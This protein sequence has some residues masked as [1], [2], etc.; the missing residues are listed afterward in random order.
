MRLST[1]LEA[2]SKTLSESAG[3]LTG[4][5]VLLVTFASSEL[6]F[7]LMQY[8]VINYAYGHAAWVNGLRVT[9]WKHGVLSDGDFL[10]GW[11]YVAFYLGSFVLVLPFFFGSL[12]LFSYIG[13]RLRGRRLSDPNPKR[14]WRSSGESD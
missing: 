8:L 2:Y 10:S 1:K 12:F 14:K 13:L 6:V 3:L 4:I 9:D 7:K 11:P 5:G